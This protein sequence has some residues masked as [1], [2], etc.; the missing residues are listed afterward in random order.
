MVVMFTTGYCPICLRLRHLRQCRPADD[1]YGRDFRLGKGARGHLDTE[2]HVHGH[3]CG[4]IG[5][6]DPHRLEQSFRRQRVSASC[7]FLHR[8]VSPEVSGLLGFGGEFEFGQFASRFVFG[9]EFV[10]ALMGKSRNAFNFAVVDTAGVQVDDFDDFASG[11]ALIAFTGKW[12]GLSGLKRREN[13]AVA[14]FWGR[15]NEFGVAH[16]ANCN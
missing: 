9:Q 6:N 2:P 14:A 15:F 1:G 11:E 13:F 16:A 12:L 5:G 7:G 8:H 10:L 3:G 4:L